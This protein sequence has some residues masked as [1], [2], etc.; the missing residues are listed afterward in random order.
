MRIMHHLRSIG[1]CKR[2]YTEDRFRN[3][4]PIRPIRLSVEEAEIV[5]QVAFIVRR[6]LLRIR[7]AIFETHAV[8]FPRISSPALII[9]PSTE[10]FRRAYCAYCNAPHAQ[11]D[12]RKWELRSAVRPR[13]QLLDP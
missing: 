1:F 6:E 7:R 3:F 2:V 9:R 5:S 8:F 11:I 12:D 13:K 10:H 4:A